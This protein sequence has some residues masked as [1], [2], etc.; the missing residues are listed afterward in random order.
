MPTPA[1]PPYPYA[2][3]GTSSVYS[4]RSCYMHRPKKKVVAIY[5]NP[6][7]VKGGQGRSAKDTTEDSIAG[8]VTIFVA[9][10][11]LAV[12]LIIAGLS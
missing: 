11:L 6:P 3:E 10:S 1:S 4:Y 12:V 2:D 9:V 7:L 5:S 8:A